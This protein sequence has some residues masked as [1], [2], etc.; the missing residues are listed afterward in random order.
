MRSRVKRIA[1]V[2]IV[3]FVLLPTLCWV[4][5]RFFLLNPLSVMSSEDIEQVFTQNFE[6]G[7]TTMDEVEDFLAANRLSRCRTTSEQNPLNFSLRRI[8]LACVTNSVSGDNPSSDLIDALIFWY[9]IFTF[10]FDPTFPH[11]LEGFEVD[12][13]HTSF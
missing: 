7:V 2:F 12:K 11:V 5:F 4:I 8:R 13:Y 1:V 10:Y 6:V 9:H 3:L